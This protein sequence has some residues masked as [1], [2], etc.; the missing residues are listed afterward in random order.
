METAT[1][2]QA[3][4][5]PPVYL[6]LM[7]LAELLLAYG[8]P[9][10][11]I[12]CLAFL[13]FALQLHATALNDR[14][15]SSLLF[16]L[17]LVPL[18]RMLSLALALPGLPPLAWQ[19]GVALTLFLAAVWGANELRL[20]PAEIGL[21]RGSPLAQGL[22]ALLGLPIGVAEYLI[23]QPAP[24]AE[25]QDWPRLALAA[26]V[27]VLGLAFA[28]E[29]LFRGVMLRAAH[30]CIGRGAALFVAAVF[31]VL[32]LGYGSP[33][34]ML[35]AFGCGLLFGLLVERSGSIAGVTLA[36]GLGS[37]LA[38]LVLPFVWRPLGGAPNLR[39][40]IEVLA[41]AALVILTLLLVASWVL[42]LWRARRR[43]AETRSLRMW[44]AE[45]SRLAAGSGEA[46]L[47]ATARALTARLSPQTV[48]MVEL[49]A[50]RARTVVRV[51]MGA[52]GRRLH[53]PE[54][55]EAPWAA[56][57]RLVDVEALG[58]QLVGR[59]PFSL[60]DGPHLVMPLGAPGRWAVVRP[61]PGREDET[62]RRLTAL[63]RG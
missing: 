57:A 21:R 45:V 34:T 52:T 62:R 61:R 25:A 31:A 33:L 43:A 50:A 18:V 15:L 39:L 49:D 24:L 14:H 53:G 48:L 58:P 4:L 47:E 29:L 44:A 7:A 1:E 6:G 12:A 13:L 10:L 36:N 56:F 22:I 40:V 2:R 51:S 32:H 35:L 55:L 28:E 41:Q 37:V 3:R 19:A 59:H 38:F 63:V 9:G 30:R 60:S 27:L 8:P 11:G 42:S 16:V 20:R 26:L 23:L 5:A 54:G 17:S 46:D